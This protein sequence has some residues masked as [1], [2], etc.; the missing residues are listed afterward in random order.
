MHM[1]TQSLYLYYAFVSAFKIKSSCH[2]KKLLV[3]IGNLS[4]TMQHHYR[5]VYQKDTPTIKSVTEWCDK[6]ISINQKC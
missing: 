3:F 4:D 6:F 1:T 2:M 5:Q